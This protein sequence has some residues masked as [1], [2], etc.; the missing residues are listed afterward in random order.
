MR[1]TQTTRIDQPKI[2]KRNKR[3]HH[4]QR[5][6]QQVE[7]RYARKDYIGR[8]RLRTSLCG[9]RKRPKRHEERHTSPQ[10]RVHSLSHILAIIFT[11][12]KEKTYPNNPDLLQ[13][14]QLLLV[15]YSQHLSNKRVFPR[16]ELDTTSHITSTPIS[17]AAYLL[18]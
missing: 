3:T 5:E 13:H 9:S 8:E 17:H 16:L 4:S 1:V 11:G 7:Q 12:K 2:P 14:L 10:R 6:L 18:M 15:P